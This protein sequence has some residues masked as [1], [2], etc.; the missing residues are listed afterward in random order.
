MKS[1]RKKLFLG[2]LLILSIFII[3][4][5]A[6]GLTFKGFF[7]KYKLREMEEAIIKIE[8]N[9]KANGEYKAI[10]FINE[11]SDNYNIQVQIIDTVNKKIIYGNHGY[12]GGF[13]GKFEKLQTISEGKESSGII[14]RDK[15]TGA[16]FLSLIKESKDGYVI[17]ARIAISNI[18]ESVHKSLEL[19][20]IV[21]IPITII[22]IFLTSFYANS[23]TKPIIKITKKISKIENLDFEDEL[24]IKSNDEIGKLATSVD[25]LSQKIS[26]YLE[27]LKMN[28]EMLKKMIE[29]EKENERLRKEFVSSVSH[30]LKSP[31]AVISGYSQML[32]KDI[33]QSEKDKK[34]YLNVIS[35]ETNKMQII[36]N[37]LLDLYKFESNTFKI[38]KKKIDIDLLITKTLEKLKFKLEKSNIQLKVHIEEAEVFVD[39]IRIE[40]VI[41]N[42]INNAISHVDHRR[43]IRVITIKE[44]ESVKISVFNT[45]KNIEEKDL[46]KIWIGFVRLDKV[47]NYKENRVGLGL[48][49]VHQ[50]VKLHDGECGVENKSD[51]VEFWIRLK[52]FRDNKLLD[53]S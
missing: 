23:F 42:Y 43:Y 36:V 31:I 16:D 21:L 46:D 40:Q 7:I 33:I 53:N 22:A 45:G 24:N 13:G 52:I 11:I 6:Y 12:G 39:E 38:N 5:I 27:D 18:N 51:G 49:I 14:L 17:V 47:R 41:I 20:I 50:I 35:D 4:I 15:S 30:E 48:A 32:N 28:N 2:I 1:I 10:N 3:G 8:S 44:E 29:K 26:S 34:Y 9:I 37:D 19:L 25:N